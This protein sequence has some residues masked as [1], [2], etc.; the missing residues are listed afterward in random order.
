M[1]SNVKK[2]RLN[3]CVGLHEKKL[4]VRVKERRLSLRLFQIFEIYINDSKI[5]ETCQSKV[6]LI[7]YLVIIIFK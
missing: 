3:A 5:L 6:W 1:S 2:N 7:I 4:S